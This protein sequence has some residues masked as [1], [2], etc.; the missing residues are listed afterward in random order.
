[1]IV[2]DQKLNVTRSADFKEKK[3]SLN[4]SGKAFKLLSSSLY[5]NKYTSVI[6]EVASNCWDSTVAAGK[7]DQPFYIKLPN[8]LDPSM[9]FRDEGV[10][11][12]PEQIEELY[13]V[14]F[15]STKTQNNNQ[16]GAWGI[17]RLSVLSLVDSFL[18]KSNW[19]GTKYIY[20]C[21][22]NEDGIPSVALFHEEPTTECNGLEVSF[23]VKPED[24]NPLKEAAKTVLQHFSPRPIITGQQIDFG[25]IPKPVLEGAGWKLYRGGKNFV[26]MG[27]VAY[28]FDTYNLNLDSR[29]LFNYYSIIVETNIGDI[30]VTASREAVEYTE[31]S[32]NNIA[33]AINDCVSSFEKDLQKELDTKPTLWDACLFYKDNELFLGYN[34]TWNGQKLYKD[35]RFAKSY[36]CD[37]LRRNYSG[38][39]HQK[40]HTLN[41]IYPR[42]DF[43]LIHNDLQKGAVN[44][45]REYLNNNNHIEKAYVLHLDEAEL[46]EITQTLGKIPDGV[47]LK[48]SEL[49]K[50]ALKTR[51]KSAVKPPQTLTFVRNK[52]KPMFS[53]EKSQV[54]LTKS[55][56]YIELNGWELQGATYS[57]VNNVL[58]YLDKLGH[59][60]ELIG[61]RKGDIKKIKGKTLCEFA[62]EVC[63]TH[64]ADWEYALYSVEYTKHN[65]LLEFGNRLSGFDIGDVI[66]DISYVTKNADKLNAL[67][68][69]LISLNLDKDVA[70]KGVDSRLETLKKQY[71]LFFYV[72][73]KQY[74]DM[75]VNMLCDYVD[76]VSK[77]LTTP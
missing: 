47:F 60:V 55:H 20:S 66:S 67:R 48:A 44:R 2:Q 32:K 29:G 19:N 6:R 13:T 4:L 7:G 77:R 53:W 54:D 61:V 26:K 37:Y 30:D 74:Y 15:F 9:S 21:F 75:P 65:K 56:V 14:L 52:R 63:K 39:K 62:S 11:L 57:F 58:G 18:L 8:A 10:G 46:K 34:A 33:K 59:N 73:E 1:M 16:I 70:L 42:T 35:I 3:F 72:T 76:L 51:T 38:V 69:L 64:E 12:S 68:F 27:P 5:S 49:A 71:P 23:S 40:F 43:V 36:N 25:E 41:Q 28:P 17:G 45:A 22:I 31:K 24:I 50:P